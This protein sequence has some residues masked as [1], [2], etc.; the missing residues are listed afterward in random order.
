MLVGQYGV[1]SWSATK[2]AQHAA[3]G[4]GTLG[5]SNCYLQAR[6]G[7]ATCSQQCG[8]STVPDVCGLAH[9]SDTLVMSALDYNTQLNNIAF[10]IKL[11]L[12]G[13]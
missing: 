7:A 2:K 4:H 9:T 11:H 5:Q 1:Q 13:T 3:S 12:C 6:G 10:A 8:I